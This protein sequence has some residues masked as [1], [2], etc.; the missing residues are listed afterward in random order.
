MNNVLPVYDSAPLRIW[1][2][3]DEN[4]TLI[5][6]ICSGVG[7]TVLGVCSSLDTSG[8]LATSTGITVFADS[9]LACSSAS[10]DENSLCASIRSYSNKN[11]S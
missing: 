11:H 6:I 5:A 7:A 10:C 8:V 9:F 2:E 3:N 4:N 1:R